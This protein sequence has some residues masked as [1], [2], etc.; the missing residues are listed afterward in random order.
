MKKT[1]NILLVIVG[2]VLLASC[3]KGDSDAQKT[4]AATALPAEA[5]QQGTKADDPRMAGFNGK[6]GRTFA[7]SVEDWPK[8]PVYTG[9]EPNVL[10]ILLDDV[11][12][13]QYGSFGGAIETPNIDALVAGELKG[14]D[15]TTKTKNPRSRLMH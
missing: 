14:C 1:L 2:A 3:T 13:A 15:R 12:F 5:Q 9:K 7:E 4:G 8:E 10:L 11:G 6:I